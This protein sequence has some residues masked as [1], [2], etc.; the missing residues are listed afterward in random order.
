MGVPLLQVPGIFVDS[1]VGPLLTVGYV[2]LFQDMNHEIV[3]WDP[4]V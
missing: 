2:D 3:F 1:G 4:D